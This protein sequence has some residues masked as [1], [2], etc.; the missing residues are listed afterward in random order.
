MGRKSSREL[1]GEIAN[2]LEWQPKSITEIAEEI[3][4]DR[5]SVKEYL[6]ALTNAANIKEYS[7]EDTRERRFGKSR[8]CGRCGQQVDAS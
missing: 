3:N 8:M 1:V 4:A 6:E 7:T 2:A 5:K